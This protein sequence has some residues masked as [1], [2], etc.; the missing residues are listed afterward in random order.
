MISKL[1]HWV[2]GD[3]TYNNQFQT[4]LAMAETNLPGRFNL[5]EEEFDQFDWSKEPAESWDQ[6]LRARCLQLR[7]KYRNLKI[8]YSG[9]RDSHC[10]LRA[11][12]KNNIPI[13]ELLIVD[14]SL[15]PVRHNEYNI[16]IAPMAQHYLQ[17]NPNAKITTL[18]IGLEDYKQWYGEDWSEKANMN[19]VQGFFQP[20]DYTWMIEKQC[21]ISDSS[22]G[23]VCGLEK[24][25]MI[26][27]ENKLYTAAIDRPF[28]HYFNNL[29]VI[30]FF[31]T[32]PDLPELQI[33]QCHM[34]A[35]YL[36][37]HYPDAGSNF[38][39]EFCSV[40]NYDEYCISLGRG[41]AVDITSPSQNARG[42]YAGDHPT[43]QVLR[44]IIRKEV[45]TVW[46]H[47]NENVN[48]FVKHAPNAFVDIFN[49]T[50]IG[51]KTIEGKHYFV[52]D[53]PTRT[54]LN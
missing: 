39:K 33:K 13:D 14:Y 19:M 41:P 15:N 48:W 42:K 46:N 38:F 11:F 23:I 16:W 44:K 22:T 4:W 40:K 32:T 27:K 10:M 28:L 53:W 34:L 6:L 17:H 20:S 51:P 24:P 21:K 36:E 12:I 54:N 7:H 5:Y 25:Y 50:T 30:E 8:L 52:R 26:V 49:K 47:Y 1:P 43:F 45:P 37:E 9:G 18:T 35:N 29:N 31:Y 3:Q 2:V